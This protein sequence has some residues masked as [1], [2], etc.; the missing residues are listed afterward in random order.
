MLTILENHI[1]SFFR[2]LMLESYGWQRSKGMYQGRLTIRWQDPN[3]LHW[4]SEQTALRLMQ[5]QALDQFYN[6]R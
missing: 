1:I 6:S 5:V 3:S 4:Y 2:G